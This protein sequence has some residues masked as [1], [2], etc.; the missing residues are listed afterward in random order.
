MTDDDASR[1]LRGRERAHRGDH[2]PARLGRGRPARDAR[3]GRRGPRAG[4]V[5]AGELE[6]VGRG[7]EELRL[8][9][10]VARLEG[11][12]EQPP[13]ADASA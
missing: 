9:E 8:E 12:G 13:A 11:G 5:C 7:L 2:P 3:A 1:H 6:A 10:L 4:R